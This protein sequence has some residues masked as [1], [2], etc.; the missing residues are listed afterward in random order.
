[1]NDDVS[2]WREIMY[3]A[4]N[5]LLLFHEVF[6]GVDTRSTNMECSRDIVHKELTKRYP[7]IRISRGLAYC[8][9]LYN[10]G[11]AFIT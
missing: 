11:I 9:C 5:N 2:I 6:D 7:T 3:T 10:I 4:N 1:M 8:P